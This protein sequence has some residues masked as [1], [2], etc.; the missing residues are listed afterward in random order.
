MFFQKN[1]YIALWNKPFWKK[2]SELI[3][4]KMHHAHANVS[5]VQ[6]IEQNSLIWTVSH[7]ARDV[8]GLWVFP[9]LQYQL[10]VQGAT[11]FL[12]MSRAMSASN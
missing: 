10:G 4:I 3:L 7:M 11:T 6:K 1:K 5:N 8:G 12:H 9:T 2:L